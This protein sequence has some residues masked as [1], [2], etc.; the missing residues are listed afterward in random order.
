MFRL[1]PVALLALVAACRS[2]TTIGD[3]TDPA[4]TLTSPA[5]ASLPELPH[6]RR[7][8]SVMSVIRRA[9]DARR[10]PPLPIAPRGGVGLRV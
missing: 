2:E 8:R 3:T 9:G 4:L 6:T 7:A 5:P 1:A 10:S